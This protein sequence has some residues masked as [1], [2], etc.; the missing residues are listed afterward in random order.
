MGE[1]NDSDL[2]RDPA[3][4]RVPHR[5][6]CRSQHL[7]GADAPSG[8]EQETLPPAR[9]CRWGGLRPLQRRWLTLPWQTGRHGFEELAS[10][11]LEELGSDPRRITARDERALDDLQST[12]RVTLR[13]RDDQLVKQ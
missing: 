7:H 10:Q 4:E 9:H 13:Q 11:L 2:E 8:P 1:S 6:K 12:G 5:H 3:V